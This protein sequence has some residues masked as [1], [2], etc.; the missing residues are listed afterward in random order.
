MG[1]GC[2]IVADCPALDGLDRQAVHDFWFAWRVAFNHCYGYDKV[3]WNAFYPG[4]EAPEMP[5]DLWGDWKEWMSSI[6]GT[7]CPQVGRLFDPH[8]GQEIFVGGPTDAQL[9]AAAT[10]WGLDGADLAFLKRLTTAG[11][12]RRKAS[13]M[14]R[15]RNSDGTLGMD[16]ASRFVNETMHGQLSLTDMYRGFAG[17]CALNGDPRLTWVPLEYHRPPPTSRAS[18]GQATVVGVLQYATRAFERH[19]DCGEECRAC[20]GAVLK[21]KREV[22]AKARAAAPA[23]GA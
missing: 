3:R 20:G 10:E 19:Y 9:A 14:H 15:V 2:C 18:G 13:S 1:P 8:A 11:P 6:M 4:A 17:L 22:L 7:P 16:I 5:F 23:V 12:D 21:F